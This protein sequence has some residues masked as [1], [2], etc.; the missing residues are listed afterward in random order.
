M[1]SLLVKPESRRVMG[2]VARWLVASAEPPKLPAPIAGSSRTFQTF[3]TFQTFRD[4]L[5]ERPGVARLQRALREEAMMSMPVS[6]SQEVL[7]AGRY[8]YRVDGITNDVYRVPVTQD[9][10]DDEAE[11]IL[12]TEGVHPG[13]L[14]AGIR[15]SRSGA[16]VVIT[17]VEGGHSH[18]YLWEEGVS[19]AIR[20]EHVQGALGVELGCGK[21]GTLV[22][23]VAD[24]LGRPS[25]VKMTSLVRSEGTRGTRGSETESGVPMTSVVFRDDNPAHFVGLQRCKDWSQLI[26]NSVARTSSEAFVLDESDGATLPV[27][28]RRAG[29]VYAVERFNGHLVVM[30]DEGGE[31]ALYVKAGEAGEDDPWRLLYAPGGGSTF[32]EDMSVNMHAIIVLER[33]TTTGLPV[34]RVLP[35]AAAEK[36][37]VD[38]SESYVVPIPEFALD[39]RF[40]ANE[41]YVSE[42]IEL[43]LMSPVIPVMR[44]AFDVITRE[45][46]A[47]A[48]SDMEEDGVLIENN[49]SNYTAIRMPFNAKEGHTVPLTLAYRNDARNPS[50]ALWIVYGAYGECLDMTYSP[51]LMS[52]MNRGYKIIWC[53]VRGGGELGRAFYE[54]GRRRRLA[55]SIAD[56]R[57]CMEFMKTKSVTDRNAIYS[58][59]AGAI[60]ACGALDLA[61][62]V[63]LES[64]FVDLVDAMRD[65]S[66]PLTQHEHDEFGDPDDRGDYAVMESVCPMTRIQTMTEPSRRPPTLV[67]AGKHDTH[68]NKDAIKR[69]S[70]AMNGVLWEDAYTGHLPETAEE[71]ETVR[72]GTHAFLIDAMDK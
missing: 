47:M 64:P 60:A 37:V 27:H 39:C 5:E 40:G 23:T 70:R 31:N 72:A 62:A 50:P 25:T 1:L 63:I 13:A 38:Q 11:L 35:V 30:S 14:V 67:C 48:Q 4:Y 22:Y 12:R 33:S 21:E 65:A 16:Q 9:G 36:D 66:H 8:A 10:A 49:L 45:M 26:I 3:Q 54:Q 44:V 52:L 58:H 29:V 51:Y 61:D 53:H 18:V 41:E 42:R 46:Y 55:N 20:Q 71:L 6:H 69:F 17:L 7:R 2:G 15:L 28:P 68:V 56:L 57:A 59:S 24:G 32:I 19:V 34:V 43:E